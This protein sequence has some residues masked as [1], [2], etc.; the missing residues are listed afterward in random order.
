M[1]LL[2]LGRHIFEIAPLNFQEIERTTT[3]KWPAIGRFGSRPGRQ[4]TGYGEDPITISGLLYPEELGGR[5]ELETLRETGRAA[6]PVPMIGWAGS[7]AM[8]AKVFGMVVIL[9]I[10][11]SQDKI[12]KAGFGRRMRFSVEVAPYPGDGKPIGLF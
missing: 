5:D 10:Y 8:A 7:D 1:P 12:N 3:I 9:E 11:D 4:F 6:R 2:A